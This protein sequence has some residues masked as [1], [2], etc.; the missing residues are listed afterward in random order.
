MQRCD[1]CSGPRRF[2]QYPRG[3]H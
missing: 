1:R 3:A 2:L